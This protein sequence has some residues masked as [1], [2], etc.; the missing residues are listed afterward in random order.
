MAPDLRNPQPYF[1]QLAASSQMAMS[2]DA[3]QRFARELH[4]LVLVETRNEAEVRRVAAPLGTSSSCAMA[5]G[6]C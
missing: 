6:C 3:L 4:A 1:V 5:T 2:P